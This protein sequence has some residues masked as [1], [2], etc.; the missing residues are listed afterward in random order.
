M[1]PLGCGSKG[2]RIEES[3][4]CGAGT[5]GRIEGREGASGEAFCIGEETHCREGREGAMGEKAGEN[6]RNRL[7][8]LERSGILAS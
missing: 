4:G 7:N 3:C 5:A 8:M 6:S 2:I 1:R